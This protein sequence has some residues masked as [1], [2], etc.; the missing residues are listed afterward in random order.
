MLEDI[1]KMQLELNDYVFKKNNLKNDLGDNLSMQTIMSA[2][3]NKEIMVNDLPNKWL[4]NYSKAYFPNTYKDFNE[5]SPGMMLMEMSAYVGDVLSF[6]I[7]QQYREMILPLAEEKR[8]VLNMAK[9]FGYQVK[10]IV[11]AHVDLTIK[12]KVNAV[13]GAE[14]TVDYSDAAIW[15]SG[16]QVTST[17]N[18]S[19]IFETLEPVDFTVTGSTDLD[20]F[21]INDETG[22]INS[23]TLSRNIKAV[24]GETKT[25]TFIIGAPTKFL[26]LKIPD[27]NLIDIISCI[28]KNGNDWYEVDFLAQDK[29]PIT[30]HY[31]QDADRDTAYVNLD[32]EQLEILEIYFDKKMDNLEEE[33]LLEELNIFLSKKNIFQNLNTFRNFVNKLF[34]MFKM[35]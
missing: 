34:S 14:A 7:D 13:E 16:I 22:L 35:V 12:S 2:V 8:N 32:N 30:T 3:D 1:F 11:P 33:D 5:T 9:M 4:V 15:D 20:T 26:K 29:I 18:P 6:Y 17:T 10:P 19:L 23:Y 21:E 31:T 27:I 24:S 28:D 25:R